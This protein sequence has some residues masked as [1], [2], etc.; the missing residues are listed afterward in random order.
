[1]WFDDVRKVR[2]NLGL[3]SL[4]ETN[5][6]SSWIICFQVH[7]YRQAGWRHPTP[8]PCHHVT[9]VNRDTSECLESMIIQN[10]MLFATSVDFTSRFTTSHR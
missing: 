9:S 2:H 7:L 3:W 4:T 8:L 10:G 1:M 5:V 6:R